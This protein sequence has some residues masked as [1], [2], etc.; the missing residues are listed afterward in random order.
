M[1]SGLTSS[2]S[3]LSAVSQPVTPLVGSTAEP[4]FVPLEPRLLMDA[5]LGW[6]LGGADD[7]AS[8]LAGVHDLI[9]AQVEGFD[10]FLEQFDDLATAALGVLDVLTDATDAAALPGFEEIEE[11]ADRLRNTMAALRDSSTLAMELLGID[12]AG[13]AAAVDLAAAI[14]TAFGSDIVD[15]ADMAETFSLSVFTNN[16]LQ[17][18]IDT[19]VDKIVAGNSSLDAEAVRTA[20]TTGSDTHYA[21]VLNG[22]FGVLLEDIT[23]GDQ[24]L[25]SFTQNAENGNRVDVAVNLPT[26]DFDLDSLLEWASGTGV[27]P[28]DL[29]VSSDA[30]QF[31]FQLGGEIVQTDAGTEIQ[32]HVDNL[33]FD[34]LL[35]FGGQFDTGALDGPVNLGLLSLGL[36][37]VTLAEFRVVIS[38]AAD[39]DLGVAL[40]IGSSLDARSLAIGELGISTEIQEVGGEEFVQ[41]EAE[42]A[43]QL[44][45][46]Q[47]SGTLDLFGAIS[48]PDGAGMAYGVNLALSSVLLADLP[49]GATHAERISRF[50]SDAS[51]GFDVDLSESIEDEALRDRM[52]SAIE[53]LAAMGMD[54]ISQ[55]LADIGDVLAGVLSSSLFNVS[56]PFTDVELSSILGEISSVFTSLGDLFH[57]DTTALGFS[58]ESGSMAELTTDVT[59]LSTQIDLE[60]LEGVGKLDFVVVTDDGRQAVTV[61]LTG[62]SVLSSPTAT[63]AEKTEAL[64]GLMNA[65]L[66]AYGF[67]VTASGQTLRIGSGGSSAPQNALALVGARRENDTAVADF[68]FATLGF[69]EDQLTVTT[70]VFSEGEDEIAALSMTS[71]QTLSF[72]PGDD[73][74]DA[75]IG[76]EQMIFTAVVDGETIPVTVLKPEDGWYGSDNEPNLEG[77]LAAF[78][79]ALEESG[80]PVEVKLDDGSF[81][82]SA[83]GP[84]GT[85]LTFG[86]DPEK[87]TRAFDLESLME[88]VNVRLAE[89]ETLA[90]ASLQ[91]TEDGALVFSFPEVS[92]E[93]EIEGN[94]GLSDL[95]LD[96]L[97]NLSLSARVQAALSAKF[98]AAVGIDLV[99]FAAA[100]TAGSDAD[101]AID[102]RRELDEAGDSE[103]TEIALGQALLDNIFFADLALEAQI[104]GSATNITGSANL[105]LMSLSFG[106]D[107]A[108]L[109]FL[110]IDTQFDFSIIGR[111][112]DGAFSERATLQN[113]IDA[114]LYEDAE[115][116][117]DVTRGLNTL[118]GRADLQGGIV[119]DGKGALLDAGGEASTDRDDLRH[120]DADDYEPSEGEIL[121]QLYLQ[122]GDVKLNVVGIE[123]LNEGIIDGVALT[124]D[125]LARPLDS[126]NYRL[127]G[128]GVDEIEALASL[129]D[130]D[131]LDS[132]ETILNLVSLAG[133][134]L[135]EKLP[136]LDQNIPL[137]NFSLL[138]AVDFAKDL[139]EEMKALRADPQS[140][141]AKLETMLEGVFGQDTVDLDWDAESKTL[142]FGLRFTFL[143]DYA[144]Q[145]P[146][147]FDLASLIGDQLAAIVGEDAASILTNLADVKG[148]GTLVF[149]PDLTMN[150]VFGIDL[151][152]TLLDAPE[153][154]SGETALTDLAT[155]ASLVE[156]AEGANDLRIRWKDA[157]TGESQTVNID[158]AGATTL[159]ELVTKI[160]DQLQTAIGD[161][162]SFGFDA[163][164]GQITLADSNTGLILSD[165]V[166]ALFGA[167]AAVAEVVE[168]ETVLTLA[169]GFEDYAAGYSFHLAFG[170]DGESLGAGVDI[171][172]PAEEGRTAEGFVAAL[173]AALKAADID[174]S[175]I[176]SRAVT[177][178]TM[179]VGQLVTAELVD[180]VI[181]LVGSNFAE[182]IG[183]DPVVFGVSGTDGGHAVTFEIFELGGSNAARLLGFETLGTV[184]NGSASSSILRESQEIGAPRV[185]LDTEKSGLKL[186]FTA[187]APDGLNL[188]LG[189]G[190][191]SI[192]V[193]NGTA[194]L[195][196]GADSTDPAHLALGF[197]DIDG[198]EHEGQY[199]FADLVSL[200]TD[201]GR[202]V[203]DLFNLDVAIGVVVDLAFQDSLGFLNPDE[204]GLTFRSDLLTTGG[205][206]DLSGEVLDSFS[207]DLINLWNGD[208][209]QGEFALELPSISDLTDF[210]SDFNILAF[211]NDPAAVLDG[212][213]M[214]LDRMQQLFDEYLKTIDLPVVGDAIGSAVTFFTDFRYGVLADA[215]EIANTPKADGTLPTTVDL[216]TGWFNDKLNEVF[217]PGGEPIQ[218]IQ[219]ALDTEGGLS[220]SYLYGA[221]NFSAV[222][223][224]EFLDIA[225]DLGLPGFDLAVKEGS[226]IRITLDYSVNIGFGLNKTGFF[227]L[228]DTD[229][230]E[231]RIG[232]TAD[233]GTFQGS[234]KLMGVLGID[235]DAI[236]KVEGSYIGEGT[237]EGTAVVS[238]S[239]GVDL[240]GT[241]GLE[242]IDR[243]GTA[244][245]EQIAIGL[246]GIAPET[247][248]GLD[249]DYEKL[250]YLTRLSTTGLVAFTFNAS[251]DIQLGLTAMIID[252][253]KSGN[254][255]LEI[256]GSKVIPKVK[257][258]LIILGGYS[259]ANDDGF[260]FSKVAFEDV[261]IDASVIYEAIIAPVLE[262][263]MEFVEPLVDIFAW[264]NEVP[265]SFVVDA[266]S[267]AFPIFGVVSSVLKTVNDIADFV[268]SLQAT[269]GQF[270]FGTFDFSN[271]FAGDDATGELD[272]SSVVM[273]ASN[274]SSSVL[275]ASSTGSTFGV[276]GSLSNGFALELPLLTDPFSA[277]NILLGK[278]DQVDLVKVHF[279]LF[280]LNLPKT[281]FV[282]LIMDEI[283]A[284]GWVSGAISRALKFELGAHAYAGL[285]A[286]YDL[287]GIVN[288]VNTLDPERL[289]DGVFLDTKPFIDVGFQVDAA[290]NLGIAGLNIGGGA[291]VWMGF[292]DPND[293]GKLRFP[294]LLAILDAGAEDPSK[295]LG[296]LFEGEFG[297]NFYL[298][299]W[300]GIKLGFI[301]LTFDID[302]VDL[303]VKIPFGGLPLPPR[304]SPAVD[305]GETAVLAV[306]SNIGNSMSTMDKDGNDVI[307]LDGPNS[308]IKIDLANEQG[309][310]AGDMNQNVGG[311]IIPAGKG[312]NTVD[313]SELSTDIPIVVYTEDGDDTI[314]LPDDGLVV[315]FL[316]DGVNTVTANPGAKGTYVI[317]GGSG[318]DTVD[319]PG[320][321]VVFFGD[322]DYGMRDLF[323]AT[324]ADK[325]LSKSEICSLLGIKED[326][327]VDTGNSAKAS[328]A[329]TD[330]D[331]NAQKVTL[332]G[333]LDDY[334]RSTQVK[335][336]STADSITTGAGNGLI[337]TGSGNDRIKAGAGSSGVVKVYA[338]AGDDDVTVAG[339]QAFIEGGAGADILRTGAMSSEVWGWG[340]A[341]GESGLL[342]PTSI[343]DPI[344]SGQAA[345]L[346]QLA[347]RD[348][349]DIIIGGAGDD[350]IFGQL[351]N[352]VIEGGAGNDML[353]GGLGIDIVGGGTFD[354]TSVKTG[355]TISIESYDKNTGFGQAVN[356]SLRDAA[357]GNDLIRGGDS[358]DILIGGGGDDTLHGDRGNDVLLGDF[359]RI[360]LSANLV[361]EDIETE[362]DGSAHAGGDTLF[363]G[364]G[365]D[366]MVGGGNNGKIDTIT[367]LEG[368]NV[369]IGD[370]GGVRGARLNEAV[371]KLETF[372]NAAGGADLIST[373]AG[374]DL[375][376]AGEGADTITSGAG[377]D[378]VLGDFGTIDLVNATV[379]GTASTLGG[380]D[381]ITTGNGDGVDVTSLVIAGSGND[382]ISAV[383]DGGLILLGDNGVMTLDSKALQELR[384]YRAPGQDA[385]P[386]QLTEDAATR[387]KIDGIAK[388]VE[389]VNAET[390]GKDTVVAGPG[391]LR[392]VMGGGDDHVTLGAHENYVLGDDGVIEIIPSGLRA[393]S[394]KAAN[395]GNDTI[396]GAA[397]GDVIAGGQGDDRIEGGEGDNAV[398]GDDGVIESTRVTDGPRILEM[399]DEGVTGGDDVILL[400]DADNRV[401]A[402]LGSDTV[403]VGDGQNV[404]I[405]DLGEI[406]ANEATGVWRA[407]D[408]DDNVTGGDGRN[409]VILSGGDDVAD[410]GNGGNR[411]I[412]DAGFISWT[413]LTA[414]E[415]EVI[416]TLTPEEGGKDRITTGS[417]DDVIFGGTGA[418]TLKATAGDDVILGDNGRYEAPLDGAAGRITSLVGELAGDD[419]IKAGSGNDIVLAG[420][421]DDTVEA[422]AGEDV[423]FG[424]SGEVTFVNATD[425]VTLEMTDVERGGHDVISSE[426]EDL[427]DDILMG[428]AGNDTITAGGGDDVILGD[429]AV[430]TFLHP[431]DRLPGQSAA[432][433]MLR[434]E[435]TRIDI[436]GDDLIY[437]GIGNDIAVAG[438][439]R[440]LMYGGV[441]Q[442][443]LIGDTAIITRRWV[444]EA[445]GGLTEWLTID[446]NFAYI[447]GGYDN[448]YG[449]ADHDVMI[450]NLGPD[451]FYG[452]TAEDAIFSDGYAGLFR[453]WLPQGF[454]GRAENDQ[455]YLYTS[456]FAGAG[457]VD[458]VS[459][460]QQNAAIGNPL[461]A[462]GDNAVGKVLTFPGRNALDPDL[463]RRTI[464]M[465][466]E[467]RMLRAMAQ[468]IAMGADSALL[469]DAMLSSLIEAGLLSGDTD[470]VMLEL[471]IDRLAKVLHQRAQNDAAMGERPLAAE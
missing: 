362:F 203:L 337:M 358:D 145:L 21:D 310:L 65:A 447:E 356:V 326:G 185:Y 207:G 92:V 13:D 73:F 418:D 102:A 109:N 453:A 212:L 281:N 324:F 289:L 64:A 467:P 383:G 305:S 284:P 196:A 23:L 116:N 16:T 148:D 401:L 240:Y 266:L 272:S 466:D 95:G 82:F 40:T 433:R 215:R 241:Q 182:S 96:A 420:Q 244:T 248:T 282:D 6:D 238:A 271:S 146:F 457:A 124:I 279:T 470:P 150:F 314:K 371:T 17:T 36:D 300:A 242:I 360:R 426:P 31:R 51:L 191:I 55:F 43:Y 287:S 328:Y 456:N 313:M 11:I 246:D 56:I 288:F 42:K 88:W 366:V 12:T 294:E 345:K 388:R 299:V 403:T 174:R 315:L 317:F 307:T 143:E 168:G 239:L 416:E 162:V 262:P 459:N 333:F 408:G 384:G 216:L 217:N 252:P 439:G 460:S 405:A 370:F 61:T 200:V 173:N 387:A 80:V 54:Q 165:D 230:E 465:L 402:G 50:L 461:D 303:D 306:G 430:F 131:I 183:A 126:A 1:T 329:I 341:A 256:G 205:K 38:H 29:S 448:I 177:G 125:D 273:D 211:L 138:D 417:G 99:G 316:G 24:T 113:I 469:A 39:E 190:P 429:I 335:A 236:T 312:N 409:R 63:D 274:S 157:D 160:N 214:I 225:F 186:E 179:A 425:I 372:S 261:R 442:D 221:I 339:A 201:T 309:K 19:L 462:V 390:D 291:N 394:V 210:L 25:V 98:D 423:A 137:L 46:L 450:G 280:N 340:K 170:P 118:V 86:A 231:I 276:F 395:A 338:G 458:V 322:G 222:I 117:L 194:M 111:D 209:L 389:A 267:K 189:F 432:D 298:S 49:S 445:K 348:G 422:G 44:A 438:F 257:T 367:D 151:S 101:N 180:G 385:T 59:E 202:S 260:T 449:E 115:G 304:L 296:Y 393:T 278:Y 62:N 121:S 245:T 142:G 255:E 232:I 361:A 350:R 318:A 130:G 319:I 123:G 155:V 79:T 10:D 163:E 264:M 286:G 74:A 295:L 70:G 407:N 464:D 32:L 28:F 184:L 233:A 140:G 268:E 346:N 357:D 352:D 332:A 228:N 428:Q 263:I 204:H 251:V 419:L 175:E 308:P 365:D 45:A 290:L 440:D 161:H 253:T 5:T 135:K 153:L 381:S 106:A 396:L 327:T 3:D 376:L 397:G 435:S 7:I 413:G 187:G 285:S 451:M 141:L 107:N 33:D 159:E 235:A 181:R 15:A 195:S 311:I 26:F 446:T 20:I 243:D 412:G 76:V 471:L 134:T 57:I 58:A 452:N 344:L 84:S 104:T 66:A 431:H 275:E 112:G 41:I 455:R 167:E 149:D 110:E 373:G 277:M 100:L 375:I 415:G 97:S 85:S 171:T 369:V 410:L 342:D 119:T 463:W 164:T 60:A 158:I 229:V 386:E 250:V 69:D 380:D 237:G 218:F 178:W 323:V 363:G 52:E 114:F 144:E 404:V 354:F 208:S 468:T 321:N 71:A 78:E 436:I 105:G 199:D 379:T 320:G 172:I 67:A 68:D 392:A 83:V 234:A 424:D 35:Q 355:E 9:E 34:P 437:G 391:V 411:V 351:G 398:L 331:G 81:T 343:P 90:G 283:G 127:L 293:D 249:L 128:E 406:K 47:L 122:L 89:T 227:L 77:I 129:G 400:G 378:I 270:V 37:A 427:G 364:A 454:E 213:D 188:K 444:D 226:G 368:S 108:A 197:N 169:E 103:E 220:D 4:D 91:L 258:E 30:T 147:N 198:D 301:N 247:G 377:G 297:I 434:L 48:G 133:E 224:D 347:Q 193:V 223:F 87:L 72:T 94:F 441:G 152:K 120:V 22:Q 443:I 156:S 336:S 254:T 334:T 259:S 14:N 132:F 399:T 219:A 93:G 136:F 176:S 8:L 269:G 374:N 292:N 166:E 27:A 192:N 302:I 359:A 421:G 18:S 2:F 325:D 154:A 53:G 139:S 382:R 414:F 330:I 75:M 353:Y 206:V 265:F 349:A